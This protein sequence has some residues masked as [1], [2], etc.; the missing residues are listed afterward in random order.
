MCPVCCGSKI[1][2]CTGELCRCCNGV[3][4]IAKELA[5]VKS[6]IAS[7]ILKRLKEYERDAAL[8]HADSPE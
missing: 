3:G 4:E 5:E 6:K 1:S 8:T 2:H 7:D